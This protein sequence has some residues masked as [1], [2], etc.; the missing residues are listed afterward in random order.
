MIHIGILHD[1]PSKQT[2]ATADP[3][4]ISHEVFCL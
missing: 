1:D 4:P 3:P 2:A